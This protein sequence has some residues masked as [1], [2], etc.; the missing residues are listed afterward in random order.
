MYNYIF[1]YLQ[2]IIKN[3]SVLIYGGITGDE[4]KFLNDFTKIIS[5]VDDNIDSLMEL[6]KV[7]PDISYNQSLYFI[8][9][10]FDFL[11]LLTNS[12]IAPK[13]YL[14]NTGTFIN[15]EFI[16]NQEEYHK[17]ILTP[18]KYNFEFMERINLYKKE[19][20][21]AISN[22]EN[23]K[24]EENNLLNQIPDAVIEFYSDFK[25]DLKNKVD[26]V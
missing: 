18:D 7:F 3:K 4:L 22:S 26:F 8:K 5:V 24:V 14:K 6:K 25:H 2:K 10:K 13:D 12:P 17:L 16:N 11:I 15:I 21:F 20:F 9:E 19:V 23:I 1:K